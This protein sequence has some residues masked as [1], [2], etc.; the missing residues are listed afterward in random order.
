MFCTR[1]LLKIPIK[2]IES[3][4]K[5]SFI[6]GSGPGGQAINKTRSCV[7]LKHIPTGITVQTQRFREMHLNRNEAR[8]LLIDKLDVHFNGSESKRQ[9][10]ID[11]I[12]KQKANKE[13]KARKKYGT[14]NKDDNRDDSN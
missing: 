10:K 11:K 12:R 5:E 8:K 4:L 2:L 1:L 14:D 3:E 7:Q 6:L 13:R 9:L